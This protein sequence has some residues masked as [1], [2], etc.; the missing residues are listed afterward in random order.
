MPGAYAQLVRLLPV[1][2]DTEFGPPA[3]GGNAGVRYPL[4]LR[5]VVLDGLRNFHALF[6]VEANHVHL[7][8]LLTSAAHEASQIPR[9]RKEAD[10]GVRDGCEVPAERQ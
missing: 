3:L 10:V 8:P 6:Q 1:Y 4:Y 2:D 7:Q 9:S 5:Q